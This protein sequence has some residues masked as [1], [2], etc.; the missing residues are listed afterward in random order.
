MS[1]SLFNERKCFQCGKS[2][3]MSAPRQWKLKLNIN[4]RLVVF[5]SWS[6]MEKARKAKEESSGREKSKDNY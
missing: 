6:C 4:N 5:C 2:F 1:G 3:V